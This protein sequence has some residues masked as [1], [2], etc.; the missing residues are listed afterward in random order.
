M[1]R[2]NS[3]WLTAV[4]QWAARHEGPLAVQASLPSG[5]VRVSTR[6]MPSVQS[7]S[8]VEGNV[9]VLTW[10]GCYSAGEAIPRRVWEPQITGLPDHFELCPDTEDAA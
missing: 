6:R 1:T 7:G 8:F 3:D 5:V 9:A 2:L 4:A 10:T